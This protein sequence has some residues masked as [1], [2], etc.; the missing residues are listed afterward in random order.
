MISWKTCPLTEE[1]W[2]K[3]SAQILILG[4]LDSTYYDPRSEP[5]LIALESFTTVDP[6]VV[7]GWDSTLEMNFSPKSQPI[8]EKVPKLSGY[9]EE[10]KNYPVAYTSLGEET[11]GDYSELDSKFIPVRKIVSWAEVT[12]EDILS[13]DWKQL[14]WS[15]SSNDDPSEFYP[16]TLKG[17]LWVGL[18]H[19]D[20][21]ILNLN[22]DEDGEFW[23]YV[24]NSG[25]SRVYGI[26]SWTIYRKNKLKSVALIDISI[27]NFDSIKFVF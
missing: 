1:I 27:G 23:Y 21:I 7:K 10:G 19:S 5:Y 12:K 8:F 20:E 13:L 15:K 26:D 25:T 24:A 18:T 4:L 2:A 22:A 6:N 11:N 14:D 16:E 9:Y 3:S 17:G